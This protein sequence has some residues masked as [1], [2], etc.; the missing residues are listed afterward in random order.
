MF[1]LEE[2]EAIRKYEESE[3]FLKALKAK[4][5][6]ARSK[7][8]LTKQEL[9][10]ELLQLQNIIALTIMEYLNGIKEMSVLQRDIDRSS[11][12]INPSS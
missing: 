3:R 6:L 11:S 4:L 2:I 12:R 10:V 8:V 9:H 7:E 1:S 5:K